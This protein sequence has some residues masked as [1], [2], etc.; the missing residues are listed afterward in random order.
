MA[1][2]HDTTHRTFTMAA[3]ISAFRLVKVTG[4]NAA[5]V[6]TNGAAIGFVEMDAAANETAT[7]KLFHPTYFATVS[8]AGVSAGSVLHAIADG[9]VASA[10]GVTGV[11][12][13]L[14]DGTT[15]D[16]IEVAIP[17]SSIS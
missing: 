13:A 11:G 15:N 2:Q 7:V 6:A 8:G 5:G 12:V 3:A 1:V 4:E 17:R 14:N 16:V 10:G 9:K